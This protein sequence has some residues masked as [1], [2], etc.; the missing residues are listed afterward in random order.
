MDRQNSGVVVYDSKVDS[1]TPDG[2]FEKIKDKENI[3]L[4]ETT[5]DGD[6]F[7][8][9]YSRAV[10]VKG[11]DVYNP[12]MFVF[13]FESH[14]RCMTPQR[15]AVI[16][17]KKAWA[18]VGFFHDHGGVVCYLLDGAGFS[19]GLRGVGSFC[20]NMSQTFEGL[21]DSTLTGKDGPG[22]THRCKRLVAVQLS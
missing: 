10:T 12:D 20:E 7:G 21:Q 6:V 5:T 9:F 13:S 2:L 15:F 8:G 22:L 1:L 11:Y 16:K 4:V 17:T 3:A 14:G 18:N 19:L